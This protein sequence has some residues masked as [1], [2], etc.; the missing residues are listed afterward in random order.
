MFILLL[1][2]HFLLYRLE[3]DEIDPDRYYLYPICIDGKYGYIDYDGN[4]RVKPNFKD[5]QPFSEGLGRVQTMEGFW[6]FINIL[7]E[8]NIPPRYNY[9]SQ[10][11]EGMAYVQGNGKKGFI[12]REG[13]TLFEIDFYAL[14]FSE[15]RAIIQDKSTQ[16][17]GFINSK[18][19]VNVVPQY[20]WASNFS[21]GLAAVSLD[22]WSVSFIDPDGQVVIRNSQNRCH[23]HWVPTGFREGLAAVHRNDEGIVFIDKQGTAVIDGDFNWAGDFSDGLAWAQVDHKDGFINKTGHFVIE[24]RFDQAWDF[25]EEVA[26]VLVNGK[27]GFVDKTGKFVIEPQFDSAGDFSHGLAEFSVKNG[28]INIV[29]YVNRKG[30]VVWQT[31]WEEKPITVE[32][33]D[34]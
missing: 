8:F 29:G 7:G 16:L 30:T 33:P 23:G 21:E 31:L 1:L 27:F 4:V 11:S 12:D 26:R 25:S 28:K 6:G 22:R 13:K 20:K 24:P 34:R 5:T 17:L 10:F 19:G 2:L 32:F 14:P 18:G 3:S 15:G 9:A